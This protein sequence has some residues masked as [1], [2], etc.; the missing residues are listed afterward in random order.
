MKLLDKIGL[1]LFSTLV[2]ILAIITCLMIF[3]WLDMDLVYNFVDAGIHG[4][5]SSNILL[6]VSMILILLKIKTSPCRGSGF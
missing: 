4:Q 1:A 2:L 6:V 5:V 3:G